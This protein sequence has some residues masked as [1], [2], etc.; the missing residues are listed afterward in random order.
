MLIVVAEVGI[1]AG[2]VDAVRD[3]L[4]TN[5]ERGITL[6]GER[7]EADITRLARA[8]ADVGV[9]ARRVA[10]AIVREEDLQ[11]Q[12]TALRSQVQDLDFTEAAIRFSTLQ[13]QLEAGVRTASQVNGLSLLD[14]LG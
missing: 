10:D 11:V 9:R 3:A 8:R 6:A 13:R 12:E 5:D 7:L 1:E 2:S 14:F 4:R